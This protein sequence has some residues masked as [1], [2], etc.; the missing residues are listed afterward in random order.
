[1]DTVLSVLFVLAMGG[2]AVVI[3]IAT[4]PAVV[5]W[6][7]VQR[8]E[9]VSLPRR[10]RCGISILCLAAVGY[11]VAVTAAQDV[12]LRHY[13]ER[14]G[15]AQAYWDGLRGGLSAKGAEAYS[16]YV[17]EVKEIDMRYHT[18]VANGDLDRLPPVVEMSPEEYLRR[19]PE[20]ARTP[21][22]EASWDPCFRAQVTGEPIS[23][24][25]EAGW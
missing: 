4:W 6:L 5:L 11:F 2:L 20:F 17:R 10:T 7:R 24:D 1:V 3:L 19:H 22:E 13:L 8:G 14:R 9:W 12:G 25:D 15:D 18:L 21:E 23:P 16:W